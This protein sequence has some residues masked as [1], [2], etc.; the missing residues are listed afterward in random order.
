MSFELNKL[1]RE[2]IKSLKPYSS[3]RDEFKG[4][5]E[6]FLDAN[7]NNFGSVGSNEN[8]NRYPDPLQWKVKTKLSEIKNSESIP[9]R[10]S[11]NVAE[12][13]DTDC[14]NNN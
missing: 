1:I 11:N 12:I 8:Y 2:N 4:K 10:D 13:K 9:V 14:I 6:V 7:E 5:A 3:A